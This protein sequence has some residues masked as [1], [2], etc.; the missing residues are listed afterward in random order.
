MKSVIVLLFIASVLY[1]KSERLIPCICSR[2]YAP[3]CASNGKSYGNKCEFLCHVKSRPHEEQKSLYIV[4]FGA[5]EEPASI[6]EL[7]EIPV[8]TLD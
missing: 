2:I 7:P 5:C 4:K 8:V 3:V 6:N 1:V